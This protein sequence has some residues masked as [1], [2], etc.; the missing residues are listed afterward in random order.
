[1]Y[2]RRHFPVV[3]AVSFLGN[4]FINFMESVNA[5]VLVG[6]PEGVKYYSLELH[7]QD[8]ATYS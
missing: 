1:M 2:F 6:H 5:G 4:G 7:A 8:S 3:M